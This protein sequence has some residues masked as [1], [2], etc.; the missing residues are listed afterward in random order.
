[1]LDTIDLHILSLLQENARLSIVELA[2]RVGLS[3]SPCSRRV[4]LL[5]ERGVIRRHVSLLDA[6]QV[7]LPVSVF[8]SVTLERQ[9][10]TALQR[11]EEAVSSYPEVMECYLMTG[12]SDYML[13]VVV[14]DLEA[15]QRFLL[16]RLTQIP[17]VANIQSSFALKQVQYKTA[18]P[19]APS[20]FTGERKRPVSEVS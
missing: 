9:I 16:D 1:M 8:V 19:L 13:R 15:Y 6:T 7:G 5:E 11:F 2:N 12:V 3:A 18:L 14:P 4:K 20:E 17:G 10:E